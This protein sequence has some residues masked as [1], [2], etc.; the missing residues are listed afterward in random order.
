MVSAT[1]L[2]IEGD[3]L[4]NDVNFSESKFSEDERGAD[5]GPTQG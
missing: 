2:F 4:S 5:V 3:P 1:R